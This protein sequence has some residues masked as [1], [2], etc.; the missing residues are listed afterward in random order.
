MVTRSKPAPDLFLKAAELV[1][2][3]PDE[4]VVVEDAAAGVEAGKAGGMWTVGLGPVERVGI[5]DLV[6]PS[7]E[8]IRL[9]QILAE[10]I[11]RS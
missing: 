3:R 6:F 4:S 11:K 9:S 8:G 2:T 10:L 7:L 5:A 1:G